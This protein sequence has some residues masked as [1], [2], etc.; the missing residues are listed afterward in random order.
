MKDRTM[1]T[2]DMEGRIIHFLNGVPWTSLKPDVKTFGSIL[3]NL[4]NIIGS[5]EYENE[6]ARERKKAQQAIN[7]FINQTVKTNN[8][9]LTISLFRSEILMDF[10]KQ[11]EAFKMS[12][13]C[14]AWQWDEKIIEDV[15]FW[16]DKNKSRNQSEGT[17]EDNSGWQ[18]N[19]EEKSPLG[20]VDLLPYKEIFLKTC[21]I[22][23]N[24]KAVIRILESSLFS[25]EELY[26]AFC[27]SDETIIGGLHMAINYA[28]IMQIRAGLDECSKIS[29]TI[30]NTYQKNEAEKGTTVI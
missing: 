22:K 2:M 5:K 18:E 6:T 4:E 16:N 20:I 28:E 24:R 3:K 12:L 8:H 26:E 17:S 23:G 21:C 7:D 10:A 14:L 1:P 27:G 25:D 30:K 29:D 13:V 15:L 11:I 9:E 19:E